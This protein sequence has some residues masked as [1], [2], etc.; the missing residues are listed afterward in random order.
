MGDSLLRVQAIAAEASAK[1]AS[2]ARAAIASHARALEGSSNALASVGA[3][4]ADAAADLRK[5]VSIGLRTEGEGLQRELVLSVF[6]LPPWICRPYAEVRIR[7]IPDPRGDSSPRFTVTNYISGQLIKASTSDEVVNLLE[8]VCALVVGRKLP[9]WRPPN[10][11]VQFGALA[12]W[13]IAAAVWLLF[14]LVGGWVGFFIGFPV[15][16]L[17]RVASRILWLPMIL[18]AL[19]WWPKSL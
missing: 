14:V 4:L 3:R 17:A 5:V 8:E 1:E 12:A 18:A 6:K 2:E 19:V 15:A 9:A 10:W 11:Y 16:W 13:M 7:P